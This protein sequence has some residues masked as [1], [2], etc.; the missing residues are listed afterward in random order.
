MKTISKQQ[1]IKALTTEP[2]EAGSFFQYESGCNDKGV[3]LKNCQVCA[4]GA[5]LRSSGVV[6]MRSGL[7]R[8]SQRAK[9]LCR[10]LF[11]WEASTYSS[12]RGAI[13]AELRGGNYLGALSMYFEN[14]AETTGIKRDRLVAFVQKNFPSRIKVS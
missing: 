9:T 8:L 5:V 7:Q 13:N 14:M 11:I 4:V 12:S 1:I 6:D 3:T 10:D 2:L